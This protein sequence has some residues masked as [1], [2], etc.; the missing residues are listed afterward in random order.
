M[1]M[2]TQTTLW[3]PGPLDALLGAWA[4]E[5]TQEGQTVMRGRSEFARVEGGAFLLQH[6]TA[7]LLPTTPDVWRENSPFPIATVMGT[8][9]PSGEFTCLYADGRGVRRVYQMALARGVWTIRGQA[10]PRFFQRFHGIF[11]DDGRAIEAY[12]ERSEDGESWQRDFDIRYTKARP[13]A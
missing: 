13:H 6:A 7:E 12:W 11:S 9:D 5:I 1:A 10:G 2:P 8:D 4:F 3:R